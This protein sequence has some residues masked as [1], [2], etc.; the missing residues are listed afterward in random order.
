M[1]GV[2]GRVGSREPGRR[3]SSGGGR[4]K[5]R[6]VRDGMKETPKA[7]RLWE[8]G[9]KLAE[10]LR[11]GDLPPSRPTPEQVWELPAVHYVEQMR[12]LVGHRAA[13]APAPAAGGGWS[14]SWDTND[15]R[16]TARPA[17]GTNSAVAVGWAPCTEVI[18]DLLAAWM[19]P[20]GARQP[21]PG[22]WRP[23]A[24]SSTRTCMSILKICGSSVADR[25][26]DGYPVA[27]WRC[28]SNQAWPM[29]CQDC[30]SQTCQISRPREP[31]GER[32]CQWHGVP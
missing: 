8:G 21:L 26:I 2:S 13:L 10:R 3:G 20:G 25:G 16:F 9:V 18:E 27:R 19:T 1:I 15:G 29:C 22:M 14:A 30:W 28:A 11:N 31:A 6:H 4:E 7:T 5:A 12:T 17:A 24:S 32:G 23:V